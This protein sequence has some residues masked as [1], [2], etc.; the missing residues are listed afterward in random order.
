[1]YPD[2]RIH[3][4]V[5]LD[6]DPDPLI[7][8]WTKWIRV[9]RGSGFRLE[10]LFFIFFINKFMSDK[11][12]YLFLLPPKFRKDISHFLL[13]IVLLCF[14]DIR[15]QINAFLSGSGSRTW[16][17][18]RSG[19]G[20]GAGF[21]VDPDPKRWLKDISIQSGSRGIKIL[22]DTVSHLV[23]QEPVMFTNI[24]HGTCSY[25]VFQRQIDLKWSQHPIGC[26]RCSQTP[27]ATSSSS[28]IVLAVLAMV[29]LH[30]VAEGVREHLGPPGTTLN[31]FVV[32]L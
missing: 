29:E 17:R 20:S 11:L 25:T 24:W 27:S 30:Q 22:S 23:E 26:W 21:E 10:Y 9:Q 6:P 7:H 13:Y 2:P 28:T 5:I 31:R 8:I 19:S 18:N 3:L 15:I 12:K 1:M 32:E 16:K 4:S 14:G